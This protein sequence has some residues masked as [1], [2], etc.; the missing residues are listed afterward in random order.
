MNMADGLNMQ[1]R[2][3]EPETS[4]PARG[5]GGAGL[6]ARAA[7]GPQTLL[8]PNIPDTSIGAV[9]L[10]QTP[11]WTYDFDPAD[12][13]ARATFNGEIV[14]S[15]SGGAV[16]SWNTRSGAV[17]MTTADVTAAGGA[18]AAQLAAYLPLAGGTLT[19]A[20]TPA[21]VAGI[22]GTTAANNAAA[23]A[24]GEYMSSGVLQGAAVA[25][26]NGANANIASLA[27]TAGD[28]DVSGSVDYYPAATTTTSGLY[29]AINTVSATLPT[30][31]A[32]AGLVGIYPAPPG[33]GTAQYIPVG[34][35]RVSIAAPTTV[36]LIGVAIFAVSTCNAG[37]FLMARRVR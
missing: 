14:Y 16:S 23:G 35:V 24:V 18:T 32:S 30:A 4:P 33:A 21:Q 27:L 1:P 9:A 22:V 36:Y 29:A 31:G 28:W 11:A 6:T 37:G 5:Q 15:G 3:G 17:V 2:I 13:I 10:Q 7:D 34:P 20:L 12:G 25:L 26:T 19:G 8:A